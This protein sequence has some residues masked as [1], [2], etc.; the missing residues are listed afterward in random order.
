MSKN[1]MTLPTIL[2]DFFLIGDSLGYCRISVSQAWRSHWW[3]R[4]GAWARRTSLANS[5]LQKRIRAREAPC[6]CH[7]GPKRRNTS[8]SF[9]IAFQQGSCFHVEGRE[10]LE[11]STDRKASGAMNC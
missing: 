5:G 6:T 9:F 4:S 8:M 3:P 10:G 11:C 2:N 1:T 7:I